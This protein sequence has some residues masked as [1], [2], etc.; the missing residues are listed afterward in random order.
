MRIVL[1]YNEESHLCFM[2]SNS[3]NFYKSQNMLIT[4]TQPSDRLRLAMT[5]MSFFIISIF[6]NFHN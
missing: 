5:F 2:S 4:K 6:S 3:E 1:L